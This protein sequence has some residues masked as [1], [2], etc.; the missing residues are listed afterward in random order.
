MDWTIVGIV[1]LVSMA[2]LLEMMHRA[3]GDPDELDL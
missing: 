3:K 2:G 1:Y